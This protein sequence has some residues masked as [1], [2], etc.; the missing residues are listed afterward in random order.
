MLSL[1]LRATADKVMEIS[2]LS[3][4]D[5]DAAGPCDCADS[6]LSICNINHIQYS[7]IQPGELSSNRQPAQRNCSPSGGEGEA[8][9]CGMNERRERDREGEEL[10]DRVTYIQHCL[11]S[12]T[13]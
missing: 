13:E 2:P 10:P 6:A 5:I 12:K 11:E 4:Q 9:N 1:H 8:E 3:I 7:G